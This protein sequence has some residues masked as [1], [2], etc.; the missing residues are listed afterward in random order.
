[1]L[2][3]WCYVGCALRAGLDE[4]CKV[5][6]RELNSS[7]QE[8]R[9]IPIVMPRG[10]AAAYACAPCVYVP[11]QVVARGT[12]CLLARPSARSRGTI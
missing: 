1:M 10:L 8:L 7:E 6:A 11:A 4:V 12:A 2:E 9:P 3:G 5:A